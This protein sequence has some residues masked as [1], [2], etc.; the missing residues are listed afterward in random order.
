[1]HWETLS[2]ICVCEL[3]TFGGIIFEIFQIQILEYVIKN[4]SD[5]EIFQYME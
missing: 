4:L 1:M 2:L 5:Q 3:G